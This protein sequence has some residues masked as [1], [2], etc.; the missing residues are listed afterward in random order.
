MTTT[1]DP[2]PLPNVPINKTLYANTFESPLGTQ[3]LLGPAPA[4][5]PNAPCHQQSVPDLN[6]PSGQVG[7]AS[8]HP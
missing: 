3:P 5:Q 8:P 1:T 4:K 6:G 2:S 7:S